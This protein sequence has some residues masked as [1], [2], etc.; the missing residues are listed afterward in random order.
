MILPPVSLP[1]P[2]IDITKGKIAGGRTSALV[3]GMEPDSEDSCVTDSGEDEEG[4]DDHKLVQ[5]A[6]AIHKGQ[7]VVIA[8]RGQFKG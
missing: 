7:P 3:D 2:T 1:N 8:L 4:S 5:I 6:Q